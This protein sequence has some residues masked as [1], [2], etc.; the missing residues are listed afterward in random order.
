M[1]CIPV[2]FKAVYSLDS[3]SGYYLLTNCPPGF[4][5]TPDE[6]LIRQH[7]GRQIIS[8]LTLRGRSNL[9]ASNSHSDSKQ[10]ESFSFFAGLLPTQYVDI[11]DATILTNKYVGKRRKDYMIARLTPSIGKLTLLYI[12]GWHPY[13]NDRTPFI[14]EV[15]RRGLV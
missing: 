3:V 11:Y 10:D 2:Y 13:P 14:Q 12:P 6:L 15:T 5:R 9:T 8:D 4:T 1:M 7:I